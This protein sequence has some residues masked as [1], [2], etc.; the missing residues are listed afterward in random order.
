MDQEISIG[1]ASEAS[2]LGECAG[3]YFIAKGRAEYLNADWLT[4]GTAMMHGSDPQ[5]HGTYFNT[6][7]DA[8]SCLA[9]YR[10]KCN[11][12]KRELKAIAYECDGESVEIHASQCHGSIV[13][14]FICDKAGSHGRGCCYWRDEW[15]KRCPKGFATAEEAYVEW[16]TKIKEKE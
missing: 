10:A 8:E 14:W 16:E 11:P 9:R 4:F 3:K 15:V 2:W 5:G 6:R 7:E 1:Q 13:S 12:P